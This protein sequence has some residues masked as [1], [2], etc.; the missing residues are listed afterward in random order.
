MADPL[1]SFA[2]AVSLII[3]V[4]TIGLLLTKEARWRWR[5]RT[6]TRGRPVEPFLGDCV[7]TESKR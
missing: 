4:G 5:R 6:R 7:E 3:I 2:N 1:N